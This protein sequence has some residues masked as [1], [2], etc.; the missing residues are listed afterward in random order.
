[1]IGSAVAPMRYRWPEK[2]RHGPSCGARASRTR[3]SASW[4]VRR[5]KLRTWPRRAGRARPAQ[6]KRPPG[7]R[8][9]RCGRRRGELGDALQHGALRGQ[10]FQLR[11]PAGGP[12]GPTAA[13]HRH[14]RSGRPR[15]RSQTASPAAV[16]AGLESR[17]SRGLGELRRRPLPQHPCTR[18]LAGRL[19]LEARGGFRHGGRWGANGAVHPN[20]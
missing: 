20:G 6:G 1:M 17:S 18:A 9:L 8:C 4:P 15:R 16:Q 10:Q 11:G 14:G 2:S 13:A 3:L 12:S 19:L 5:T 7:W